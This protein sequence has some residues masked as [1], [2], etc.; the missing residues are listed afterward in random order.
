MLTDSLCAQYYLEAS[1]KEI[2]ADGVLNKGGKV[3]NNTYPGPWIREFP[4]IDCPSFWMADLVPS[5]ACWG[6]ELGI[7]LINPPF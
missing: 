4:Y 3:F 1:D 2:N 6:D 5:E 7:S